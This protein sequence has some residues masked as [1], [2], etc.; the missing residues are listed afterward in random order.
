MDVEQVRRRSPWWIRKM[1]SA[2]V[3]QLALRIDAER[4]LNGCSDDQ[5]WLFDSCLSELAYRR[6]HTV[7]ADWCTCSLCMRT[8]ELDPPERRRRRRREEDTY[9]TE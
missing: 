9:L 7:V 1:G 3:H 4:R 8:V 5:E 2:K 6:R